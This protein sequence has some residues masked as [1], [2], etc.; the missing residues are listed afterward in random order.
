MKFRIFRG[1][2]NLGRFREGFGGVLGDEILDF[3][4]FYDIF[5]KRNFKCSVEGQKIAKGA[6]KGLPSDGTEW[7]GPWPQL[8][9]GE[10]LREG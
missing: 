5:S 6:D 7:L 10:N 1:T 8:P 2:T 4:H 9:L 3:L